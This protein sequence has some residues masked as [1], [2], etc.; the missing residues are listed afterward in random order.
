MTKAN[1]NDGAPTTAIESENVFTSVPAVSVMLALY[2]L[3][4]AVF[5][6]LPVL[7]SALYNDYGF[8]E[9]QLG[10]FA[11]VELLG[12]GV[13]AGSGVLWTNRG[14]WRSIIRIGLFIV[15]AGNLYTYLQIDQLSF[16]YLLFV[17]FFIGLGAGTIAAISLSFIAH[18][19]QPDRLYAM[20]VSVQVTCQVLGL[21][22]LPILISSTI[23]GG[24]FLGAKGI[25]LLLVVFAL[26][27]QAFIHF[28]PNGPG[29][30]EQV[31]EDE[32]LQQESKTPAIMVLIAFVMF[33]IT[34]TAVWGFLELMGQNAGLS[35]DAA[36]QAVVLSVI[37]GILGPLFGILVG[38]KI[39]RFLPISI[40]ALLQIVALVALSL[41]EIDYGS[42]L[43]YLTFFQIGWNLALPY[44]IGVMVQAD[45]SHRLMSLVVTA[46]ALGIALGPYFAG[47]V[48][49]YAGYTAMLTSAAVSFV[50]YCILILP[51]AR[52]V[53]FNDEEK[54]R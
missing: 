10:L 41:I 21:Y 45:P 18:H 2:V 5:L 16:G 1:T 31:H 36:N 12:M 49:E 22:F 23:A 17:R 24:L 20:L 3:G 47:L 40:A 9:S 46:Q 6:F 53:R 26:I 13:S 30:A 19:P 14:R 25:F 4:P 15:L 35:A 11:T 8:S 54:M 51:N 50:I 43:L 38:D 33:F 28:M 52:S 37:I 48:V 7:L 42:Y 39:G 44:H 27:L 29:Q 32:V 34:Q